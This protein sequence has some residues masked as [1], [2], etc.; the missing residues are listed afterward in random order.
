MPTQNPHT[1]PNPRTSKPRDIFP[2][3]PFSITYSQPGPAETTGR[4]V[5]KLK[6]L[7]EGVVCRAYSTAINRQCPTCNRLWATEQFPPS[8]S[9]CYSCSQNGATKKPYQS[10]VQANEAGLIFQSALPED[11]DWDTRVED[12]ALSMDAIKRC[13]ANMLV[14][15]DRDT[16]QTM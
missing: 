12:V 8:L 14:A 16:P 4:H 13:L 6:D 15:L 3:Q 10:K 2:V 11:L 1:K 5:A 7:K 9:Q